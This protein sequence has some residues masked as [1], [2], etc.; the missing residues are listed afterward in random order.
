[1]SILFFMQYF[2]NTIKVFYDNERA[3]DDIFQRK[4]M[5][6]TLNES[7]LK[8]FFRLLFSVRFLR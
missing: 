2:L 5:A 8:F 1:M 6:Q 7:A 3:I 4:D